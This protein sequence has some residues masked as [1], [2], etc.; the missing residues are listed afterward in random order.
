MQQA[1]I[2]E[3]TESQNRFSMQASAATARA[4]EHTAEQARLHKQQQTDF[5]ERQLE[6]MQQQQAEF[7]RQQQVQIEQQQKQFEAWKEQYTMKMQT[8]SILQPVVPPGKEPT[9]P[10]VSNVQPVKE[11][12][13]HGKKLAALLYQQQPVVFQPPEPQQG[14]ERQGQQS[15]TPHPNLLPNP[16]QQGTLPNTKPDMQQYEH[17][18]GMQ[19]IMQQYMQQQ[20][21]MQQFGQQ[22]NMQQYGQLL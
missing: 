4:R 19:S 21:G 16:P 7:A 10:A 9:K 22:P 13:A 17:H 11:P 5:A 3:M 6:V 20:S 2:K 14:N 8:A 12:I 15:N 18:L 1:Q